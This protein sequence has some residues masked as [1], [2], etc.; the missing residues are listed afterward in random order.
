MPLA[1]LCAPAILYVAFST[2]Q[3]IID[4]FKEEYNTAFIKLFVTAIFAIA[5]NML[6]Q[7][8]LGLLSWLIVFLPFIMMTI[9]TSLLLFIFKLSPKKGNIESVSYMQE[10][11]DETIFSN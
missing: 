8:G 5:L 7:R 6:C 10:T 11:T 2:T 1:S 9:I 3:I 4:L